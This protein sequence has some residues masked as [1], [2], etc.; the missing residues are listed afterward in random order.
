MLS[1]ISSHSAMFALFLQ[2]PSVDSYHVY[3][4]FDGHLELMYTTY[5]NS[6]ELDSHVSLGYED[7]ADPHI[8]R[9]IDLNGDNKLS[10]EELG[11]HLSHQKVMDVM[12]WDANRN[13][14][15]EVYEWNRFRRNV[16]LDCLF[17]TKIRCL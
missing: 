3:G 10:P 7:I 13:G 6:T 12:Q 2:I 14:V 8:F 9:Q 17:E 11:V 1:A 4:L 16:A 5:Q 15:L